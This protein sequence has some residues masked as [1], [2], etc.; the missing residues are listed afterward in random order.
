M[1]NV[2]D[3]RQPRFERGKVMDEYNLKDEIGRYVAHLTVEIRSARRRSVARELSEHMEDAVYAHMLEGETE[4]KAF[5][6]A[7][8][9]MGDA[10]AVSA[11]LA[12]VHTKDKL[13]SWVKRLAFSGIAALLVAV[14]TFVEND[15]VRAWL[16]FAV[17]ATLLVC[18]V[19]VFYSLWQIV[20]AFRKRRDAVRRLNRYAKENG[21]PLARWKNLIEHFLPREMFLLS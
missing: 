4:E 19:W 20:R 5:R 10:S 6:S 3:I 12:A 13:P 1:A 15:I 2:F 14:Y 21:L 7:C 18:G 17:Q 9:E 16:L 11:L 8:D